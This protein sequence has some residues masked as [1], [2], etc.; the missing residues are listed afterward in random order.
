ML[1]PYVPLCWTEPGHRSTIRLAG[2]SEGAPH[3][4]VLVALALFGMNMQRIGS[5]LKRAIVGE[6]GTIRT[7]EKERER[8]RRVTA[9]LQDHAPVLPTGDLPPAS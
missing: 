1:K 9:P 3:Q 8:R 7:N 6:D 4:S 5:L 2:A